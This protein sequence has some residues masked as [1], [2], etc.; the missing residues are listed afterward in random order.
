[1]Q[2]CSEELGFEVFAVRNGVTPCEFLS[3]N[4]VP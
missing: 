4:Q 3:L 2:S 1:M